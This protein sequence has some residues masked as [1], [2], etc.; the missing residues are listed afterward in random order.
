MP[1]PTPKSAELAALVERATPGNWC[2]EEP[3]DH[4]QWIVEDGKDSYEWRVIA[5]CPWSD[6]RSDIP[7]KQQVANAAFIV[8]CRNNADLLIEALKRMETGQ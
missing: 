2:I 7:R 8:W 1:D 4:E 6:D 5:G 3:M